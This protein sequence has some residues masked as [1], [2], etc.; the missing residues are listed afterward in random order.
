M[1]IAG[2]PFRQSK[3]LVVNQQLNSSVIPT[4]PPL[5][6]LCAEATVRACPHVAQYLALD[7]DLYAKA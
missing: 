1:L 4:S 2:I 7:Y 3:L 6:M 5:A